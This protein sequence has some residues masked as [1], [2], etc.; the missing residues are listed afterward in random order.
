VSLPAATAHPLDR[1]GFSTVGGVAAAVNLMSC[2]VGPHL[3]F[4]A[5]CDGGPLTT[6]GLERPDQGACE[7]RPIGPVW[8]RAVSGRS[9]QKVLLFYF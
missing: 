6:N 8:V 7:R 3:L 9:I 1:L 5:Q 4:I 2:A